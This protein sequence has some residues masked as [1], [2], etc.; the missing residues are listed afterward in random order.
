MVDLDI[1]LVALTRVHA[2]REV[3]VGVG[4]GVA[5]GGLL[6]KRV[7]RLERDRVEPRCR[8]QIAG[9]GLPQRAPGSRLIG[10]I[11]IV[12]GDEPPVGGSRIAEIAGALF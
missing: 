10:G 2:L 8:Y 12:D 6:G 3:V 4:E 5:I 1:H 9:E 11:R 7:E